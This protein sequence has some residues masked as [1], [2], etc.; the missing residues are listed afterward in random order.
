MKTKLM[1]YILKKMIQEQRDDSH[2]FINI[3]DI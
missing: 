2:S 1:F 3:Y